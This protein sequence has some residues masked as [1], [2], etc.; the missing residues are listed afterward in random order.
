MPLERVPTACPAVLRAT[1]EINK[2]IKTESP[3]CDETN[4]AESGSQLEFP[5]GSYGCICT[6][7]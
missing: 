7:S 3:K 5:S 1:C 6:V 2:A 4:E